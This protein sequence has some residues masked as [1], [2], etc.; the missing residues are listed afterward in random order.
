MLKGQVPQ[1]HCGEGSSTV[2][3]G[4]GL[5]GS[6]GND[7]RLSGVRHRRRLLAVRRRVLVWTRRASPRHT[8]RA[9]GRRT[10]SRPVQ[11]FRRPD[12]R[13]SCAVP[14]Y[15]APRRGTRTPEASLSPYRS[16]TDK[17][18]IRHDQPS[19]RPHRHQADSRSRHGTR[20]L[21]EI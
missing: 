13:R 16:P 9:C 8:T 7:S 15:R 11:D 2:W 14:R 19:R 21:A 5:C 20:Y 10:P 3:R 6:G 18:G 12:F 4:I 1:C 17:S